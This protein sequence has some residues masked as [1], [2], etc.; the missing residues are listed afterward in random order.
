[1]SI[2]QKVLQELQAIVSYGSTDDNW[3]VVKKCLLLSLPSPLRKKFS[4]RHPK[5]KRQSINEFEAQLID[6]YEDMTGIT[7]RLKNE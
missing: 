6:I 3:M 5:T 1:V 2:P 4:T 7:L